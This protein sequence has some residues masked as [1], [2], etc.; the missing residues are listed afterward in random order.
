MQQASKECF[1]WE[2]A[3]GF[4]VLGVVNLL[5]KEGQHVHC[6]KKMTKV[7]SNFSDGMIHHC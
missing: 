6:W 3:L 2:L 5:Q 4:L 7:F 1:L